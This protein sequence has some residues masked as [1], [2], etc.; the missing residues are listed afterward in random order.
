M[1]AKEQQV[2]DQKWVLSR[3]IAKAWADCT[4]K[5][6]LKSDPKSVLREL[7]AETPEG[8]EVVVVENTRDRTYLTLPS[9]PEHSSVSDDE[10]VNVLWPL[11]HPFAIGLH[12]NTG[13]CYNRC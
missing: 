7:G 13:S 9:A 10:I 8:I 4:F 12:S 5:A 3:V 1:V 6:R 11:G 2:K